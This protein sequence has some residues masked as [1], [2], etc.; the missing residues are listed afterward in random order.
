MCVSS[1]LCQQR[2]KSVSQQ[3]YLYIHVS[4]FPSLH[5]VAASSA[6]QHRNTHHT[7][8]T[9]ELCQLMYIH[10]HVI[11]FSKGLLPGPVTQHRNTHHT[12]VTSELCQLMYI[13]FHVISSSKG[14]LPLQLR[15]IKTHTTRVPQAKYVSWYTY[16]FMLTL[17]PMGRCLISFAA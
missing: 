2:S 6:M 17:S 12:C 9:S 10:I 3:G 5:W 7:C 16:T 4:R 14:L 8:V 11:S 1:K 13:Y 15:S